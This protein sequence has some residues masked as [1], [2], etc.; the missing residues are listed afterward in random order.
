MGFQKIINILK[1]D[2]QNSSYRSLKTIILTFV[3]VEKPHNLKMAFDLEFK[4]LPWSS[5][6]LQAVQ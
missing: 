6:L 4:K 2:N 3:I 5:L 1:S